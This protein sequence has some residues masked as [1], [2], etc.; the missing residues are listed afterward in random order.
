MIILRIIAVEIE[1]LAVELYPG[2][3]PGKKME[4]AK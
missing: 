2:M 3:E 1:H 4:G